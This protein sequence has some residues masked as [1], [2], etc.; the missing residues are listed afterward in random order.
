VS[1]EL[2]GKPTPIKDRKLLEGFRRFAR[3]YDWILD[4]MDVLLREYP[5][6]HIAV[7]D[8]KVIFANDNIKELLENIK[9]SGKDDDDFVIEYINSRNIKLLL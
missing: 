3:D 2:K 1:L 6:K 9:E 4:N 7:A 5:D 8:E